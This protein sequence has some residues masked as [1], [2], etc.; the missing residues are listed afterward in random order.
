MHLLK[1]SFVFFLMGQFSWA[2]TS[3]LNLSEPSLLL[4]RG[5]SSRRTFDPF[6]DY[7]EFQDNVTE[8]QNISFFQSGRSLSVGLFGGYESITL[9][10]RELYGDSFTLFGASMSFFFDLNTAFQISLGFP[11]GH[12]S[13][14]TQNNHSFSHIALELKYYLNTQNLVEGIS[15]FNPYVIL[16]PLWFKIKFQPG[17]EEQESTTQPQ[18]PPI[19]ST[20]PTNQIPVTTTPVGTIP[21]PLDTEEINTIADHDSLGLKIGLGFEI[22]IIKQSYIG[23]EMS[24]YLTTLLFENENLSELTLAKVSPPPYYTILD[25]ILTPSQPANLEGIRYFGDMFNTTVI[26]GVNF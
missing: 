19:I 17:E 13:S 12:F 15:F 9:T 6:I 10:M 8:Q 1:L 11:R 20:Q 24:Y 4:A 5:S 3:R 21:S 18:G 25:R 22:P 7:S 2:E 23:I 14:I 16:G 26:L